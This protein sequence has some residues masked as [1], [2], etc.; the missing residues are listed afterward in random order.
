M[1]CRA[2]GFTWGE[3]NWNAMVWGKVS[4][5]NWIIQASVRVHS[6]P[7]LA[8]GFLVFQRLVSFSAHSRTLTAMVSVTSTQSG[9]SSK[10]TLQNVD[11]VLPSRRH[12]GA[13]G[14][15]RHLAS[16]S[17]SFADSE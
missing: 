12:A 7:R 3:K 13:D 8:T 6:C 14:Y 15:L 11:T 9:M 5:A 16:R 2:V 17:P 1:S 10:M 4:I